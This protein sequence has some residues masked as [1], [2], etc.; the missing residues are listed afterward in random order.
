LPE[1][2]SL[3][4]DQA[5]GLR[6]LFGGRSP[7]VVAFT[8]GREA[9][10]RTTLLVQSAAALA[11]QGH[12]VVIVD[13][14]P[15]PDN[16][17][18]AFGISSKHDLLQVLRGERSLAQVTLQAAP[19]IRILPAALAAREYDWT[20]RAAPRAAPARQ[21]L[22]A[23]FAEM[24]RGAGFVLIDSAPARAGHLSLLA[25][26]ARHVTVVVAA[27]GAAITQSYALVKRL[28]REYARQDFH[29]VV[30]R[31]RSREEG[32]AIFDNMR[33]V[34]AE[35]LGVRLHFLG[36]ARV[37]VTDHLA[38]ELLTRLPPPGSEAE[39]GFLPLRAA[40]PALAAFDSVV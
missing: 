35:H 26:A 23:S 24:Q 37:P 12:G 17:L 10:A 32:Q 20:A 7:Q 25:L 40:R 6:R 19:L 21:R 5:A 29:V 28:A 30:S 11:A 33:R 15:G 39:S 27:Q 3:W 31:A 14:N 13:E 36:E 1:Q 8:S 4:G 34:A 9:C 2:P 38:E 18:S 22:Q 16:S